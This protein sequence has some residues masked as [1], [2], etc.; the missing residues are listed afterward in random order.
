[1]ICEFFHNLGD[2]VPAEHWQPRVSEA[3]TFSADRRVVTLLDGTEV[4]LHDVPCAIK[5]ESDEERQAILGRAADLMIGIE[6]GPG[7][8]N[9]VRHAHSGGKHIYLVRPCGGASGKMVSFNIHGEVFEDHITFC[10]D[11][12]RTVLHAANLFLERPAES[13]TLPSP[14]LVAEAI[15]RVIQDFLSNIGSGQK[16][17]AT[18]GSEDPVAKRSERGFR[19]AAAGWGPTQHEIL[20][21]IRGEAKTDP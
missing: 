3:A 4:L 14:I 12:T 18:G 1:M 11:S 21:Q 7:L 2:A 8:A 16:R 10:A 20:A 9:E 17:P 5:G 6:G 19:G 15:H 13:P